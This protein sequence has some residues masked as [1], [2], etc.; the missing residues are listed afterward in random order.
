MVTFEAERLAI[1]VAP[2]RCRE[3]RGR[4]G[5]PDVLADVDGEGEAGDVGGFERQV[6]S[7][8]DGFAR[9]R[10]LVHGGIRRHGKLTLLVELAI[11]GQVG[12]GHDAEDHAAM[13]HHRAAM[14]AGA[15]FQRRADDDDGGERAAGFL[16][17]GDGV[18]HGGEQ[19]G[20]HVQ[21]VERVAGHA[22]FREYDE[23]GAGLVGLAGELDR[24][25]G[26][27]GG[28]GQ[29]HA[30][31]RGRD[32]DEAMGVQVVERGCHSQGLSSRRG[33]LN[34]GVYTP[35]RNYQETGLHLP[36]D[37]Y[38]ALNLLWASGRRCGPQQVVNG[39]GCRRHR[40]RGR[41]PCRGGGIRP[42][43]P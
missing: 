8:G 28:V 40:S 9:Q 16:H 37:R 17:A 5:R 27:G 2:A 43:R 32:A 18:A 31:A 20:L 25:A 21:V 3:G 4:Q 34:A 42:E 30:R 6:R 11:V 26:V 15:D 10:D 1:T 14:D 13:D 36:A 12:L 41:W 39:Y 24:L 33:G 19:S 35:K 23:G 38:P 29:V 7:E 22:E